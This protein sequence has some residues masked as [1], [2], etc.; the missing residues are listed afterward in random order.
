MPYPA[1][2]D[3]AR[4]YHV[5]GT[6]VKAVTVAAGVIKTFNAADMLELNDEDFTAIAVSGVQDRDV[7]IVLFFPS[8][9]EATAVFAMATQENTVRV[10]PTSIEGSNDTSNGV[11]GSWTAGTS[12]VPN[13]N[14]DDFDSWRKSIATVA[15]S[16]VDYLTYRIKF[17][18]S[19][20]LEIDEL[21]IAHLYGA[22]TAAPTAQADLPILFLDPDDSDNEFG[23]PHDFGDVKAGETEQK[24]FKVKNNHGSLTANNVQLDVTD[25]DDIIRFSTTSGGPWVITLAMGNIAP[26][27]SSATHYIKSEP[28]APPTDLKP[29]RAVIE[30]TVGSWT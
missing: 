23:L 20:A 9:F 28:P 26:G 2:P 16:G 7:Y 6:V 19:A 30:A 10:A 3:R 18:P 1:L 22:P 13:S 11:D 27:A 21:N 14:T 25:P 4:P 15:F 29:A 8:A 17:D 5:D 12:Y 24:T